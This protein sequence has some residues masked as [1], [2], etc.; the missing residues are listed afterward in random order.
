MPSKKSV[1]AIA[2]IIVIVFVLAVIAM[3]QPKT[4]RVV[5]NQERLDSI[6][7]GAVKQGPQTDIHKP[8]VLSSHWSTPVPMSGPVNSAGAED[9]PFVTANGTWF[10]FFFTPDVSV[11]AEKQ[12]ID[13]VTGI[14][15]TQKTADGWSL[16]TKVVLSDDVSLD[17][18]EF[19][20]GNTM[21]FGSVRAGNLGEIDVYT[22]QYEGGR[23]TDVQNA[24]AQ[25]NVDYDIGEFHITADGNTMYFHKGNWSGAGEDMDIWK[26]QKTDSGW[27]T[28]VL[29][30]A[31]NS[32][33]RDDGFPFVTQDGSQLLFTSTSTHGYA[34]PSI[35][36]SV[37]QSNG[38]WG[39]PEEIIGNFAGEPSM[40][41]AGNLYFVHHYFDA[42]N[43]MIEA[44]IYYCN[45]LG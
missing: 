36:R 27:S 42:A 38:S 26:S 9:S 23:W 10:F 28:P 33:T 11:P 19:V 14:W 20:Q 17:G 15:W 41:S 30:P 5:T 16:P 22:A 12:L 31:V 43:N 25:L 8:V 34:G 32:A 21:W 4:L 7:S 44:D 39:P 13:G 45:W 6:P 40:D 29:V 35:Y 24:G 37:L 2:V 1:A 3:S 18:A